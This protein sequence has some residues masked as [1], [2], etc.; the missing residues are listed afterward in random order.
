MTVRWRL[1]AMS[2]APRPRW[3]YLFI[4]STHRHTHT[5]QCHLSLSYRSLLWAPRLHSS[6]HILSQQQQH[7]SLLTT[8]AWADLHR[9]TVFSASAF[10][11]HGTL[12]INPPMQ[13]VCVCSVRNSLPPP[14]SHLLPF[15]CS[16]KWTHT[17][18]VATLVCF[19]SSACLSSLHRR[20]VIFRVLNVNVKLQNHNRKCRLWATNDERD[21]VVLEVKGSQRQVLCLRERRGRLKAAMNTKQQRPVYPLNKVWHMTCHRTTSAATVI[22]VLDSITWLSYK[23][24]RSN[25]LSNLDRVF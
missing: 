3:R 6:P 24:E 22:A 20:A 4:T 2:H 19:P 12:N 13:C 17:C 14:V 18:K 23:E 25:N 7:I 11:E 16:S 8:T 21:R 1:S 15:C 10:R 9:H 5:H